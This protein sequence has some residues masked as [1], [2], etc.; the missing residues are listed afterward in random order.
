MDVTRRRALVTGAS[1]GV[2]RGIAIGLAKAGWDAGINY[3]RDE[4]GA[5]QTASAI[6]EAG[7]T[8]WML[9][10]DVGD[11]GQVR[12]MFHE[13]GESAGGPELLVNNVGVQTWAPLISLA[14]EDWDRTIRTNLKRTFLCTQQ[15]ALH[16]RDHG[17]EV[18]RQYRLEGQ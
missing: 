16:M 17:G 11:L 10:A 5:R 7:A 4:S 12:T 3:F 9:Q 1:R 8:C 13:F 14:E 2:G 15:A 6:R 18:H